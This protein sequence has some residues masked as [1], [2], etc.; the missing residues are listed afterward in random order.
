MDMRK[1]KAI[2]KANKE[3][4]LKVCPNVPERSGIYFLLREENGFRFG[5]IGQA[6]HLLSRLAGHLKGYQHIDLSLRKHGLFSEDNPCGYKIHFLEFP[7]S[8]LDKMEQKYIKQYANAGYQMRNKTSGSQGEGKQGITANK[9]SKGYYDGL[10]QGKKKSREFVAD[11]FQ[12]HL[13]VNTKKQPPTKLQ[14]KALQKFND[15]I[16]L[17]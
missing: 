10:E 5:Y 7:E 2:E 15:F 12:K 17:E 14:E 6:K 9:S 1:I 3:R 4:V 8:S 16:S 13:T 11:L